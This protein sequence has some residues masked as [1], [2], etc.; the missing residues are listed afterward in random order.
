[1]K[2][3]L[4]M[5]ILILTFANLKAQSCFDQDRQRVFLVNAQAGSTEKG[6]FVTTLELSTFKSRPS[7]F[8]SLVGEVYDA[9]RVEYQSTTAHVGL[10]LNKTFLRHADN[11]R[12][13]AFTG[14][15]YATQGS[16]KD[17][18]LNKW[19]VEGGVGFMRK[20][21]DLPNADGWLR[22]NVLYNSVPGNQV[23]FTL[24]FQIHF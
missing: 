17:N 9:K 22:A 24:G 23:M 19:I 4:F 10:R 18:G 14:G 6:E 1:M 16:G 21:G 7:W 5:S 20:L 3:L 11:Y 2:K 15:K 12:L 13:I 8:V